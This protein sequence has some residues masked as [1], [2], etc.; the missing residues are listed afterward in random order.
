MNINSALF[1]NPST[2]CI[3]L[4]VRIHTGHGSAFLLYWFMVS[5]LCRLHPNERSLMFCLAGLVRCGLFEKERFPWST[6]V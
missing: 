3:H 2:I 4:R 6:K 1:F 5:D